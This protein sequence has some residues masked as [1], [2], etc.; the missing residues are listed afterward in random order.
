MSAEDFAA[1]PRGQKLLLINRLKDLLRIDRPEVR[2]GTAEVI[3]LLTRLARFEPE[4]EY[5]PV[6]S[7]AF[8]WGFEKWYGQNWQG[9]EGIRVSL[10]EAAKAAAEAAH[11]VISNG[12]ID[13]VSG[14]DFSELP[15]WSTH[16]MR[17]LVMALLANA[18]CGNDEADR[19]AT[20]YDK[21]NEATHSAFAPSMS[22]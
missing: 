6:I 3:A 7:A 8:Q 22:G 16:D 19:L 12:F 13:F 10:I 2:T 9:N 21:I 4:K 17:L 1:K 11:G 20:L 15:R 5:R 14:K 18:N